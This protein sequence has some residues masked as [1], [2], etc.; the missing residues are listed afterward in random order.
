[1]WPAARLVGLLL[2]A[3]DWRCGAVRP[4]F[5][6]IWFFACLAPTSSIMPAAEIIAERR[7]Y[8]ALA[9]PVAL[10]GRRC[11]D[12]LVPFGAH[13]PV[14]APRPPHGGW[15]AWHRYCPWR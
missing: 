9:G 15:C 11:L 7:I 5:L 13:R 1:V 6:G 2:A 3:P 4:G 14:R 8:L 10:A 12:P